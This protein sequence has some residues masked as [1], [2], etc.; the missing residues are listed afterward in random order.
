MN[1]PRRSQ[2]F[3]FLIFLILTL[4]FWDLVFEGSGFEGFFLLKTG[5]RRSYFGC[6]E[7]FYDTKLIAFGSLTL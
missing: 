6:G 5:G 3:L 7:C 2:F 1:T 4:E